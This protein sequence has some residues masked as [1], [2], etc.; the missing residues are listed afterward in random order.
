MKREKGFTLIE[1][2]TVIGILAVLTAM[3][4]PAF[5]FFERE[6][7]LSNSAEEIINALRLA[8]NRTLAS[9]GKSSWGV[10]FSTSTK[11]HQYVLFK[12]TDYNSRASSSDEIHKLPNSVEIYGIGLWGKNEVDFKRVTGYSSSTGS[13]GNV[14]LRLKVDSSKTKI[15]YVEN[16]GQSGTADPATSSDGNRIKDSRH[17]HFNYS[18]TIATSSE[19]LLLTFYGT[20][21][22]TQSVAIA[23]SLKDGQ[24]DWEGSVLVDGQAQKLTI[25]T[26]RLNNPDTLFCIYRDGDN[27]K[28]LKIDISDSPDPDLGTIAEY[29]ADGLT[30]TSTSVY[31][32]NFQW[33]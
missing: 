11:P 20:A 28:L 29:S 26:L 25:H 19:S 27:N 17:V 13:F 15:V 32:S 8:Q 30:T 12:G 21:T 4:V 14:S 22:A 7:D 18:R 3:A 10:Y 33:Q 1:L 24:I 6:S 16:S 9:E 31:I 2:L 5:H 23:S